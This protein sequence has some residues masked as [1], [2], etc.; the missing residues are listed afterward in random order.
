MI[1]VSCFFVTHRFL[2]LHATAV[3]ASLLARLSGE[4]AGG[5]QGG[6]VASAEAEARGLRQVRKEGA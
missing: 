1:A 5:M 4:L 6:A 3:A 2:V